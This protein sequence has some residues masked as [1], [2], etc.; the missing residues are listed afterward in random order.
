MQQRKG[1]WKILKRAIKK[2]QHY[3]KYE[4]NLIDSTYF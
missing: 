1:F 2:Q 3:F 4:L